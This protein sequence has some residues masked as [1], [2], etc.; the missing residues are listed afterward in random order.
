MFYEGEHTLRAYIINIINILQE[1]FTLVTF[2][3]NWLDA[4]LWAVVYALMIYFFIITIPLLIIKFT[5]EFIFS[6]KGL[7]TII[8][9]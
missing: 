1:A 9:I 7:F 3:A 4:S 5:L 6:W 2:Q 8:I